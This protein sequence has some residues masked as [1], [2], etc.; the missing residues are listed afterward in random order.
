MNFPQRAQIFEIFLPTS[1]KF[2]STNP[3]YLS[4]MFS[5]KGNQVIS[6]LCALLGYYSDQWVDEPILGFLSIFSTDEKPTTQFDFNTFLA[7][8]IYKQFMNFG[9][10][11]MFIYSSILAYLFIFFQADKFAFSMQK[12]D[13][14]GKPQAVTVWTSLLKHNSTEYNFKAFIDLFYHPVVSM[15][16]GRPKP[17][18]NDEVQR[19]LHLSDNTKAG[20]WYLYQ[21]HT[22]IR[23]YGCE[24]AHYKLPKYVP[25]RIFSL[26]Y[27]RQIMNLDDIHFVSLKKKQQLRIKGQIGSFI[28]NSRGTGEEADRMLKEMKF[29]MSFPWHYDPY[30]IISEM[31]VKNKNIPYVHVSKP[32]IEKF[33]NQT[34]WLPDTLVEVEQQVPLTTVP[35]MTMPQ[36]PKEKRPR[37][38]LSLPVM[39]VSSEEFQFHTKRPKTISVPGPTREKEAPPTIVTKSVIPPLGSSLHKDITPVVPKKST[40]SPLDTQPG[41]TGPK[42]S[43]FEKYEMIKKKNQTLTSSTYA[44]F[45]KKIRLRS[46]GCCLHLTQ[47]RGECTWPFSRRRYQTPR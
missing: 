35:P 8:N 31:R 16:S 30:G 28:C 6:S 32:E 18:I 22:E 11:G 9:M 7:D 27:I 25:V 41:K 39:E 5:I 47:K 46:I 24:L 44:Q 12:M 20:D 3:P 23:V 10:E 38:D 29:F 2:P 36:V 19:I 40:D 34:M 37:Q 33:A 4:S 26:E 14:D 13:A 45:Q 17:R 43:I 1:T 15:L 42:L 21:N